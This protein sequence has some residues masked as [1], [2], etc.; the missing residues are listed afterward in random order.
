MEVDDIVRHVPSARLR[1]GLA[2]TFRVTPDPA[3]GW[4]RPSQVAAGAVLLIGF[5]GLLLATVPI[6]VWFALITLGAL[7]TLILRLLCLRWAPALRAAGADRTA[8]GPGST[9]GRQT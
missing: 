3:P 5:A 4:L 7:G 2:V 1:Q 8:G 6:G 9:N